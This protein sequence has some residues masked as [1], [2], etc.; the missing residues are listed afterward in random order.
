M[1]N[2]PQIKTWSGS[3]R[4]YLLNVEWGRESGIPFRSKYNWILQM[5]DPRNLRTYVRIH[6][7]DSIELGFE[8]NVDGLF[9]SAGKRIRVQN[10]DQFRAIFNLH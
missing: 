10:N 7:N 6:T 5:D 2:Q 3:I 4:I 9:Y 1:I 8:R